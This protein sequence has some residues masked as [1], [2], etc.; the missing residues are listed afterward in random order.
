MISG[1]GFIA[2][3]ASS[4]VYGN[5]N[6]PLTPMKAPVEKTTTSSP[7]KELLGGID[8]SKEPSSELVGDV[9]LKEAYCLI[10]MLANSNDDKGQPI[11]G[12]MVMA[13]YFFGKLKGQYPDK[14][15]NKLITPL[16]LDTFEFTS[17]NLNKTDTSSYNP[18]GCRADVLAVFPEM[19]TLINR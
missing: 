5:S 14:P 15:L 13:S 17:K 3:W 1:L 12:N 8:F 19:Q 7:P 18:E 4:A 10:A 11:V 16:M 9:G 2:L 6:A